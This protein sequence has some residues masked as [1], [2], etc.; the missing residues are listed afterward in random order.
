MGNNTGRLRSVE[1][2][3]GAGGLGIGMKMAGFDHEVV[4]DS[5]TEACRT[6]ETN[7]ALG[8]PYVAGWKVRCIDARMADLSD[9][10]PEPDLATGGVPCQPWSGGGKG[11]GEN[12][13]R[14]M[15]PTAT[16]L[17]RRMRPRAFVFEN[18]PGLAEARFKSYLDYVLA[19][20]AAP[21]DDAK[22]GENQAEHLAR[23]RRG[24]GGGLRYRVKTA[25]LAA[26]DQ[27]TAQARRRL[28]IVGLRSDLTREW[29]PPAP[30]RS[31]EA[32]FAD[33]WLTGRYWSDRGL[34]QPEPDD[35]TAALIRA[36][37]SNRR[38]ADLFADP[39]K[40]PQAPHRTVRDAIGDMPEPTWVEPAWLPGHIRAAREARPY[41][42]KHTGTGLDE[43]AKTL[44]A[45]DHGVGGGSAMFRNDDGRYRHF[46]VREAARLQDFHDSYRFTGGWSSG[47]RQCGNAVPVALARAVGKSVAVALA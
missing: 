37:R 13:K 38:P 22:T 39:D 3:V 36:A 47:L 23:L 30:V 28:F 11:L 26:A 27:G 33:Q 25:I 34:Q 20:L 14:N 24:A 8:D 35:R 43:P 18:V 5:D 4:V 6:I 31:A 2:F 21:E 42:T 44:R 16:S 19:T 9:V 10:P 45:G 41:G 17:V 15:W 29:Q 40:P 32:L 12:D 46:T 1:F 7:Q